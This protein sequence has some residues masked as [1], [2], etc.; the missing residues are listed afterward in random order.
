MNVSSSLQPDPLS[1]SVDPASS[2]STISQQA[3]AFSSPLDPVTAS[4]NHASAALST[5]AVGKNKKDKNK[6]KNR[7]ASAKLKKL[8]GSEEE[9]RINAGGGQ[10][11]GGG[12]KLWAPDTNFIDGTAVSTFADLATKP[13]EEIYQSTRRGQSFS[14]QI[15]LPKGNYDV[16]LSF[17][18]DPYITGAG[19]RVFDITVEDKLEFDNFDI[20]AEAGSGNVL[21]KTFKVKVD[22]DFLD[23]DFDGVVNDA[24]VSTIEV[25]PHGKGGKK[26]NA[27]ST[28]QAFTAGINQA[29]GSNS[30][31]TATQAVKQMAVAAAAAP[32]TNLINAG[33][34]QY[35]DSQSR[36]WGA[37]QKFTGGQTYATDQAITGTS[38][39][40]LYKTERWGDT[41]S[42]QIP[43]EAA[44][45]YTVKLHFAEIYWNGPGLRVF[46]VG[47]E[48]QLAIND[49][50]IWSEVGANAAL[51]K[52]I[53]T[54]VTD[55]ILNIDF[56]KVV[57]NAKISAI[58]VQ[59]G[60]PSGH[61]G[62]PFLHV[63]I[64]AP[65]WA[66]DYEGNGSESVALKGSDSHT[67]EL[68]NQLVGYTWKNG[69]TTLGTNPNIN[70]T[71]GLGQHNVSLTIKDDN[72]PAETLTSSVSLPVYSLNAVGGVLGQYYVGANID[73]L[74]TSPSFKEVLPSLKVVE[75]NGNLGS[76]TIAG[77]VVVAMNGKLNVTTGG[78]YNFAVNGGSTS[79]V[80]VNNSLVTAPI[81]L[82]AGSHNL[83]VRVARDA[84][85][86]APIEVLASVSGGAAAPISA[87]SLKHDQSTLKPFINGLSQTSGSQLGGETITIKGVAFFEGDASN[88]VKVH[89]GSTILT[90]PNIQVKQGAITFVAPAGSGTVQVKVETPKG[91]SDAISYTYTNTNVPVTFA[92]PKIV[93]TPFAPTQGEWGPDG[94]LYV[95]SINGQIYI[96][97]FDDNYNVT[98]TQ[99][100]ET[101][102]G[103]DNKN[104]LGI[105]FN[106]GASPSD[107]VKIYVAHSLLF[108]NG[109]GAF[110]G[111]S[112]YSGQVSVLQGPNFSTLQPLITGLPVSNHDHGVNGLTFDNDGNLLIA[113]GGNTNAGV[114]D[115]DLGDLPESPFSAAI[116]KA[117]VSKPNF[118]GAVTYIN[119]AT[120]AVNNDQVYGDLVNV[121]SNV[122]ISVYTPGFRNPFDIVW[123]TKG[124]LY[125]TDNGPNTGYGAASTSATTQTSDPNAPDELNLLLQNSYH[126]HPN[127]NRGRSDNR[128]NVYYDPTTASIS[129]VYNKPLTTFAPSTNGLNE[130]RSGTFSNQIK[131]NLLAQKWNGELYNIDLSVDGTAVDSV[132]TITNAPG[133]L[134][135]VPGPGGAI[136]G[137]DYTDDGLTVMLP[138]DP[139][140]GPKAYDIYPWRAPVQGGSTFVIGGKNF[141]TT[142]T[143]V[144]IGGKQATL[145]SVTANRIKGVIPSATSSGALLDVVVTSGG[146]VSTLSEAFLY[147]GSA[148][149]N[150][151]PTTTGISNVTVAQNAPNTVIDLFAAFSDAQD[152]DSALTYSIAQNTNSGLF[153]A[154]TIDGT[155]GKLTL[156]YSPTATGTSTLKV[157]ATDKGGLFTD[158]TFTVTVNSTQ[159]GAKAN[160]VIG[161]PSTNIITAS[162]YNSGAFQITNNSTNGEKINRVLVDLSTAV[163]RDLVFDPSGV[164]GDLVAK[165]FTIDSTSAVG[166]VSSNLLGAHDGGYDQLEILFNGFDPGE[167]FA[168][169]IDVDPTSIKGTSA[170]GPGESGSISGLELTG[171]KVQIDFSNSTS[172]AAETYRAPSSVAVSQAVV[173]PGLPTAPGVSALGITSTTATVSNANQTIRV[174]GS[175]GASVSLMVMEAAL[176]TSNGGFDIDPYE[177]NTALA[178]TEK[179]GTIGS[180]GYVDI[181]VTLTKS[182]AA[183]GLNHIVAVI[184]NSDGSTSANS[185]TLVL[186]LEPSATDTT[187]PTASVSKSNVTT[188]GSTNY[189]F[190][191]TYSDNVAIDAAD[192]NNQDIRVTGPNSFNQL[193]TFVSVTPTGNGTPRTA[194]Y[195]FTPPGGSW[196]TADNGTYTIAMEPSQVSDTSNNFVA[197]GNLGTFTV[198][199]PTSTTTRLEAE[200][201]TLSTYRQE[202]LTGASGG[203]VISL[204]GG[205]NESGTAT[206]TFTGASGTYNIVIGY[207]DENDGVASAG[208]KVNNT[209]ISSWNFDK[210]LG[211][212]L[213]NDQTKTQRTISGVSLT[214]GATIQLFGT[215]T[216]LEHARIDYI[217]F[218]LVV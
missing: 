181:P 157:R 10:F 205:P 82:S 142:A 154:T 16:T 207:Y 66:I 210:N 94:R 96:Y 170:P 140:S 124:K 188:G 88:Q 60:D 33:G 156:D 184:Q 190:T 57:E 104:I 175:N 215:E 121:A 58:E 97:T 13:D 76:S 122:D 68:G 1:A 212:N 34:P 176:F 155:T 24:L 40:T 128:Q 113:V 86:T 47:V 123:T 35:T 132:K 125:G 203:K 139:V 65:T 178:V 137:L 130:Y 211:S 8:L 78:T 177:A 206:T 92:T 30:T 91:I 169:S 17:V 11:R 2:L 79:R 164:A 102:A 120:G 55:G 85:A 20:W 5:K 141:N 182:Q 115:P 93:G 25:T 138:S 165:G 136:I 4:S 119:P 6:I 71:L 204:F 193:A 3:S 99:V 197:S 133:V 100:V 59:A 14:Y 162:T 200:T 213:A 118:N 106:P 127:R 153:T 63:V 145:T 179:T 62:H 144:T 116:L 21:E 29:K 15:A 22:D 26:S 214:N 158:A 70:A 186:K 151:A 31:I 105:A 48:G 50:D 134:D 201:M 81:S 36:I 95:G 32:A 18:E 46:D 150:T 196:N 131:G 187:A 194:T 45:N 67:H 163:F 75:T 148:T 129:G 72:S 51:I 110:T 199:I 208:I 23:I 168:F 159:N 216:S 42:Y 117:N 80:F 53:E 61:G 49:L 98:A 160:V 112:P 28:P 19:Q 111:T 87:T 217:D 191:V 185:S 43:V 44:G 83:E 218:V 173:R 172:Y 64:D 56:S 152:A 149:S 189:T 135:V 37:D 9:A 73:S 114:K 41:F 202:S 209:T 166:F 107:P 52:T 147:L 27:V 198:N 7:F 109:G 39:Q 74:P 195:Q 171:S 69:S 180:S 103:L 77:N 54:S 12:G 146:T 90:K 101:I 126:G 167:Q 84:A 143:T 38:D 183:G 192:L 108:A 89:W 174:T 161:P